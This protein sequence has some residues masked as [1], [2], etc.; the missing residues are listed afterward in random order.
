MDEETKE[1]VEETTE[2]TTEEVDNS[3]EELKAKEQELENAKAELEKYKNKDLNFSNL[4]QQKEAAE[5]K[6]EELT[7]EME[8]KANEV[9]EK[10]DSVKKEVFE[11]VMKDHYNDTI[12]ALVGDDEE[13]LKKVE[14]HYN[15]LADT[16]KT[17]DEV[18]SKLQ[19]AWVLAT[20]K[21]DTGVL[22]TAVISSGGV[23]PLKINTNT[24]FSA[25]EK[26]LAGSF[27]LSEE[28]LKKYGK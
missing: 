16:A 17:K 15:R 4:R 6:V 1:V 2:Q 23:K 5:A 26:Q 9:N 14:Y 19:D 8:A 11:G 3:Q 10:I 18:T 21:E 12:K 20:K 7:K 28:D 13:L 24:E 25:E 27:G 22:N